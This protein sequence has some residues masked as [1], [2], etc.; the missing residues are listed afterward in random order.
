MLNKKN[1]RCAL[2]VINKC[3]L[4]CV[5]SPKEIEKISKSNDI[6]KI[7]C[8]NKMGIDRLEA[9][10]YN[11]IWS[12]KVRS[13]NELMLNN[14]RHKDA[15]DKAIVSLLKTENAIRSNLSPEFLSIDIKEGI[16][17]LGEIVGE[18]YADDIL[19]VIFSKFCIGK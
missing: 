2:I 3:D 7:S 18:T 15:V 10:V 14:V 4:K 1:G 17:A 11:K 5:L 19:D 6:I 13:S 12:G 9:E 16:S 8:L